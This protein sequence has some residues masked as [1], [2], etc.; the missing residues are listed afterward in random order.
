MRSALGS[1]LPLELYTLL[2]PAIAGHV[3]FAYSSMYW[4]GYVCVRPFSYD[5]PALQL[6]GLGCLVVN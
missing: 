4:V 5:I 2:G 1:R 6:G 3:R